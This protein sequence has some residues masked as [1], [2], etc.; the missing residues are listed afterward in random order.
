[1]D[2]GIDI[3]IF[4]SDL[5]PKPKKMKPNPIEKKATSS[6]SWQEDPRTLTDLPEV[7]Q[8]S[9]LEYRRHW[10]QIR[11]RFNRQNRLLD[12]YNYRLSSPQPQE[13]IQHLDEI[14]N[15]Q[16]TVFKLNV[17]FGFILRNNETG[18]LQYYYASRNNDQVFEEPFQI[19]TSADLPHVR[20][21]LQ[22]LDVLEWVRQRRPNSKWVVQQVTN[23]T[24]FI[25]KIRG[26]PIG[27][28][29]DLPAYLAENHGLV[30]LD[31]NQQ[32]GKVYNDNLCFFRALALHNGCHTK[33]LERDA[34]HYYE[35]Y[36]E[37]LFDRKK[38][39][40][41]KL[42]ELPDIEHLFEV[43]IFVHAL[44]P[45][46]P[47]GGEG[48]ENIEKEEEDFAP[49]IAA[50]LIHRSLCHYPR[51]LYLNLYQN[52]FSY[53]KDLKKYAKSYSCSRCGTLWKHVGKLNRHEQ[54]CEAKV[55]YQFPGGAYKTPLTLFQLLEDEGL[56]I[57]D[58]LKFFLCRATFDFEC[59]FTP[60]T[61]L[62]NTEKTD[63]EF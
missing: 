17:S 8:S 13:V 12:W 56:T 2:L 53:I 4:I 20:E 60:E 32:T 54:T 7:Q 15:D 34:K 51:T 61:D 10:H 16:S 47:D 45:I 36:R 63:A 52:H 9:V 25:T 58:H 57:P 48:D 29:T 55:L 44:E 27:R 43:N 62:N 3:G 59:M 19:T 41:V 11:T 35:K 30:A 6:S 46:K 14:F 42:K 5:E 26:H 24:F 1:M 28:G 39:C 50:R 23:I 38:F 49:E 33:N 22:N 37:T 31:R 40:G 21:A 18:A